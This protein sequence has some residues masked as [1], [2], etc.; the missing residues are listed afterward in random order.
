MVTK[1]NSQEFGN[2]AE[3]YAA[4][5]L[6]KKG[7]SLL[8]TNWRCGKYEVDIIAG[9]NNMLIFVEVKARTSDGFGEPELFV[10]KQ[11]QRFI[12][13]AAAEYIQQKNL[14]QEARFDVVALLKINNNITVKH[15]EG[16]FYPSII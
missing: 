2:W 11:K 5:I 9:Y 4:Q 8:E 14:D 12:I 13:K 16:A 1:N 10:T 3:N 6:V 7:Y 15:L